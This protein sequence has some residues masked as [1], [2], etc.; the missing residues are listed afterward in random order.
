MRHAKPPPRIDKTALAVR[1]GA[2][3]QH[4]GSERDH[5]RHRGWIRQHPCAIYGL[6]G[7][8]CG[9]RMQSCPLRNGTDGGTA[10]KPH[11]KWCWP[12]CGNAHTEQ[13]QIGERSF[14]AKYGVNLKALAAMYW[15]RSP[16]RTEG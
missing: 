14:Q 11:D 8:V 10:Q 4:R 15:A 16:F 6:A 9:G 7:H 13:H 3:W 5:P 2:G 1:V 12:G